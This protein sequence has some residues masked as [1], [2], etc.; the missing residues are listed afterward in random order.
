[1]VAAQARIVCSA[2]GRSSFRPPP[3]SHRA[4]RASPRGHPA[5][6][7]QLVECSGLLHRPPLYHS[8]TAP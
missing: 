5:R 8:G 3:V 6:E 2:R 7:L 1:M 4:P